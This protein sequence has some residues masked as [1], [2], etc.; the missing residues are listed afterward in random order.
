MVHKVFTSGDGDELSI[1]VNHVNN[2]FIR[3]ENRDQN[4]IMT[5]V[6]DKEDATELYNELGL[7]IDS[8]E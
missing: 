3:I 4:D 7:L 8:V 1:Y 6:L 2:L 5:I